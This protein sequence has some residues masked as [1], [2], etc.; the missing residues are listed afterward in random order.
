MT[1]LSKFTTKDELF[2]FLK[3]NKDALIAEKKFDLKRADA[4]QAVMPSIHTSV[5]K[6]ATVSDKLQVKVVINTTNLLDSH[7]DVH[8]DGLWNKSLKEQKTLYLLQEH[9]MAFDHIITDKVSA[10]TSVFKWRDIGYDID[11]TT[12]ALV[13]DAL[14]DRK[15][16]PFMFEQYKSGYVLNHSV[17]MRYVKLFLAIDD[18]R[19]EYAAEKQTWDKYYPVVANK[20]T[21]DENGYFWAVTEAKLVEGSAVPMGSNFVTPTLE[22]TESQKA[23]NDNTDSR[24]STIGNEIKEIFKQTLFN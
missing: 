13:F 9:K 8:I 1:D 10:Y 22:I 19:P 7:G 15:R 4:I 24:N 6:A 18:T 2:S 5:T 12:E 21:V 16:N 3:E 17:G 23:L 20:E 14:I 11:G